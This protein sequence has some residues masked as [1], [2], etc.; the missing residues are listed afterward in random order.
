M[1]TPD[2]VVQ[3]VKIIDPHLVST[4]FDAYKRVYLH[5]STELE[6]RSSG[7]ADCSLNI[8][9]TAELEGHVCL[10]EHLRT[11]HLSIPPGT[12]VQYTFPP[13]G[14]DLSIVQILS[15]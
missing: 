7:V 12:R 2:C 5:A 11:E 15:S 13:V 10:V 6:N 8:Q 1:L 4:F 3:L 9:V 14:G